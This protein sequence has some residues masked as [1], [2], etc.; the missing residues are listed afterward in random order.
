MCSFL[1][2][3]VTCYVSMNN[4]VLMNLVYLGMNLIVCTLLYQHV[5]IFYL[6]FNKCFVL[7]SFIVGA[8]YVLKITIA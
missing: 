5:W 7:G 2:S 4:D 8:L 3:G 1:F 6:V